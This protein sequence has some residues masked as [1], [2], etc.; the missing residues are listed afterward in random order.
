MNIETKTL[1]DGKIAYT[2]SRSNIDYVVIPQE[3]AQFDVW[4]TNNQRGGISV[5]CYKIGSKK[6]PKFIIPI[7]ELIAA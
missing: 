7:L 2:F 4:K 1:T 5:D 3:N 6:A